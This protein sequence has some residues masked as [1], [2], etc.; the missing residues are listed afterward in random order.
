MTYKKTEGSLIKKILHEK[1]GDI[2]E[3]INNPIFTGTGKGTSIEY[4]DWDKASFT[5]SVGV[6]VCFTGVRGY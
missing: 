3:D 5:P 1:V 2:S 6:R 4:L